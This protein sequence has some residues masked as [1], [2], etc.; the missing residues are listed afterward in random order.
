M[1]TPRNKT[2]R[3]YVKWTY[4]QDPGSWAPGSFYAVEGLTGETEHAMEQ[5]RAGS[6]GLPVMDI[7]FKSIKRGTDEKEA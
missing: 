3:N 7:D 4:R 1:E 5:L 2:P 6:L